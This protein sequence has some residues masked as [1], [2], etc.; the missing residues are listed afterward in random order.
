MKVTDINSNERIAQQV[1]KNQPV[2]EVQPVEREKEAQSSQPQAMD[3]VEISAASRDVQKIQQVLENTPDVRAE[4][5]QDLKSRV[6]S[7]EYKVD[8]REIASKMISS[9]IQDLS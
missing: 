2:Q 7:G 4:K 6:Q 5:V 9:L 3:K 8:S 1:Q